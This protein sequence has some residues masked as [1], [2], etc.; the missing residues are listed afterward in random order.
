MDDKELVEAARKAIRPVSN[1][2]MQCVYADIVT[3]G[4]GFANELV[5]G[6][7]AFKSED[8]EQTNL[9]EQATKTLV[10]VAKPFGYNEDIPNTTGRG[11]YGPI[12]E[13]RIELS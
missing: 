5:F 8:S 7:Q 4:E 3:D 13:C 12:C 10:E 11:D 9:I 1:S 2:Q 6:F